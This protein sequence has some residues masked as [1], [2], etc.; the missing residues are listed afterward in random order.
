[1]GLRPLRYA[2]GAD[3]VR[4]L[5]RHCRRGDGPG[6]FPTEERHGLVWLLLDPSGTLDLDAALGNL[7][8][9]LAAFGLESYRHHRSH[10]ST[11]RMSWKLGMDSLLE[12][13]HVPFLHR[14]WLGNV[15]FGSVFLFEAL[16]RHSR[17]VLPLPGILHRQMS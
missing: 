14:Q 5:P 13:Y 10:V 2:Q 9:E 1:M 4:A 12:C 3:G 17:M 15:V 16:G 6:R 8:P 11:R 7:G